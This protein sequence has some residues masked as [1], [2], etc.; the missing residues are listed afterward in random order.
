MGTVISILFIMAVLIG[1]GF[2]LMNSPV[3][4]RGYSA[5]F[6]ERVLGRLKVG[7]ETFTGRFIETINGIDTYLIMTRND[8]LTPPYH[9]PVSDVQHDRAT[10]RRMPLQ[11]HAD[12]GR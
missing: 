1:C 11:C 9:V 10:H 2:M 6:C 12:A 5:E 3:E 7:T 8:D 4:T